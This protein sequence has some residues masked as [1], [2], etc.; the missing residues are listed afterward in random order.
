MGPSP[1]GDPCSTAHHTRQLHAELY[2][3]EATSWN[4]LLGACV[5]WS[6][7]APSLIIDLRS[8]TAL[9]PGRDPLQSKRY[10]LQQLGQ[11]QLQQLFAGTKG[12]GDSTGG[13][14]I[15]VCCSTGYGGDEGREAAEAAVMEGYRSA[16]ELSGLSCEGWHTFPTP[17]AAMTDAVLPGIFAQVDA[18][19]EV[20]KAEGKKK[21]ESIAE[22]DSE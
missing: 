3:E 7:A 6:F 14:S 8:A 16:Y 21:R 9:A 4:T 17:G 18:D 13:A 20:L 11:R 19:G 5:A 2:A 1:V 12:G 15:R 22:L 10:N